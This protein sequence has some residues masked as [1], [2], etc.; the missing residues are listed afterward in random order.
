MVSLTDGEVV[1]DVD[2]AV[3]LRCL[4][5]APCDTGRVD[6]HV[7]VGAD[8]RIT[9]CRGDLVLQLAQFGEPLFHEPGVDS[10]GR[11]PAA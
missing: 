5:M 7:D 3:D 10:A 1:G 2:D 8:E 6:E 4:A 11:G 9:P